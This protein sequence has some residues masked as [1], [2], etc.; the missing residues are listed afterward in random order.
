VDLLHGAGAGLERGERLRGRLAALQ[1]DDLLL[2]LELLVLELLNLLLVELLLLEALQRGALVLGAVEVL[3]L[4]ELGRHLLMQQR[5]ALLEHG[6][7]LRDGRGGEGQRMKAR[8]AGRFFVLGGAASRGTHVLQLLD[9]AQGARLRRA[10]APAA[11]SGTPAAP[12]AGTLASEQFLEHPPSKD[13]TKCHPFRV[14][15]AR[16]LFSRCGPG[17]ALRARCSPD[18]AGSRKMR[19]APSLCRARVE[20]ERRVT[21]AA[22]VRASF[23]SLGRVPL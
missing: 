13:R 15:R 5:L 22:A 17:P 9:R 10:E 6:Q 14:P 2:E 3:R 12:A 19:P 8:F 11:G 21:A 7:R 1:R 23:G 18:C 4:L 20:T 16:P